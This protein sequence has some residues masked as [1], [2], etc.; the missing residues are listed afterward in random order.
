MEAIVAASSLLIGREVASQTV[1]GTSSSIITRLGHINDDYGT[2]CEKLFADLDI[3][4]KMD[5]ISSYI[6]RIHGELI[7]ESVSKCVNYI[8]ETLVEIEEEMKNLQAIK[9]DYDKQWFGNALSSSK[10]TTS[11]NSIK[12]KVSILD[13]RFNMLMKLFR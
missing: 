1:S 5:I 9:N 8:K 7:C 10:F 3:K 12:N 4:F 6:D 13:H 2:D 11:F